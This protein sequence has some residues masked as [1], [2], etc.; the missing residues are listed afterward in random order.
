VSERRPGNY[1]PTHEQELLLR[2]ALSEGPVAVEAWAVLR[3]FLD[4]DHMGRASERLVPLLYQNLRRHG[5]DDPRLSRFKDIYRYTWSRNELLFRRG[6]MLLG[7]LG[8][9]GVPTL[10]LK[11]AALVQACYGG[12]S[13]LRPMNDFDVAVPA[14]NA[15]Q[16]VAVLR[17]AGWVPRYEITPSFL[18][19]KHAGVFETGT[20]LYCDL[21]WHVFE[22]CCRPSDDDDLWHAA[23]EIDFGGRR[24]RILS[25]SDQLLH[26]CAHGAK[27]ADESGIRWIADAAL[28]LAGGA[29]DW[30]RIVEQA[31][32]RRYVV[33]MRAALGFL[34]G[35]MAAPVPDFV[36]TALA[37]A[38]VSRT[39]RFE[40]RVLRR[41][42]RLLGQLLL[43]WCH[44]R[45]AH[46]GGV[47]AAARSFP[48]YL[49][50]A[51]GLDM[52][53]ELPAGALQRARRRLG[54][55]LRGPGPDRHR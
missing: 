38:P 17:A 2:A 3:P 31:V 39:E 25:R 33:R 10:L 1:W 48:G 47:V 11:G 55:V 42:H 40:A 16:A 32:R 24:T 28:V 19:I 21:H 26:V 52:L 14:A 41:E 37:A 44:H 5:I 53:R 18:R 43:Y 36:L 22:E 27:W 20:G 6:A 23:A 4:L 51:W 7:D 34:R 50:E 29:I 9:A 12:D 15:L 49:R 54:R 46:D 45:R 8:R 30:S 13:G 35:R